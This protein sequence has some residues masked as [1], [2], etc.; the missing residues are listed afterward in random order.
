MT[1]NVGL[2]KGFMWII[3]WQN[4]ADTPVNALCSLK[5]FSSRNRGRLL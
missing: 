4:Y 1:C 3:F 2:F 5:D